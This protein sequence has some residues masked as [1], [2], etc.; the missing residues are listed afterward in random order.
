[1]SSP[2]LT[3]LGTNPVLRN[4]AKDASQDAIRK[5]SSFLAPTVEVP[6]LTGK[7]KV[8]DAK[9]R[10]KRPNTRRGLDGKATRIGFTADDA[11]YALVPRALDYPI[12]D[13]ESLNDEGLLNQAQYGTKLL[14]DAAGLDD[15]A[16]TIEKALASVGAGTDVNF[17]AADFDPIT[18]L[19]NV[20]RD[21]MLLAKNA[22]GIRVLFGTDAFL[23]I[24]NNA[25]V[26]GRFNGATGAKALK[27]PELEDVQAMLFGKPQVQL[28]TMVEDVAK[29]GQAESMQFMLSA[30]IIVFACSDTPNTMDPSFMKTFRM[31]GGFMRPGTYNSEDDRD[32]V[33]KLDWIQ[34]K[35]V[36]N[37][38]AAKRINAN[39]A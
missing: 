10:Y 3:A 33:L 18:Y 1:M 7:Y 25:K 21:V 37:S 30:P 35:L 4:F 11:N 16:E 27:V 38:A 14:A 28:A 20:I 31:M 32:Q 39:A 5:I 8:Y 36:T 15:E 12:P 22:A 29:E 23:R 17:L 19:D 6:T 9:H 2:R 24:K 26:L 13:L 34:E